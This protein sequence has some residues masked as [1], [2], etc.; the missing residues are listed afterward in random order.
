MADAI[1]TGKTAGVFKGKLR[2]LAIVTGGSGTAAR[3][4]ELL[5]GIYSWAAKRDLVP[6]LSPAKGVRPRIVGDRRRLGYAPKG[7]RTHPL[8][9]ISDRPAV[10]LAASSLLNGSPSLF[11]DAYNDSV[12]T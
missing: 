8:G 12:K 6:D 2:G 3:V 5:G 4:V 1:A 9:E 10:D 11:G 7:P